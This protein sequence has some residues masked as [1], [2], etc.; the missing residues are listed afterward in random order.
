MLV[1][2]S[3]SVQSAIL[4]ALFFAVLLGFAAASPNSSATETQAVAEELVVTSA[5]GRLAVSGSV[6]SLSASQVDNLAPTHPADILSVQP[7]VWVSRGSGQEHLAGLRSPVLTGPGACGAYRILENGIP[8]RPIGFCNVNGL[9]ELPIRAGKQISVLLGGGG[10]ALGTASQYAALDLQTGYLPSG[11]QVQ[12]GTNGYRRL[13]LR[14]GSRSTGFE[15]TNVIDATMDDGW[16]ENTGLS[17]LRHSYARVWQTAAG[18][19]RLQAS[20]TL[21][22]QRTAGYIVVGEGETGK[23]ILSSASRRN[24]NENEGAY[25]TAGSLRLSYIFK[26]DA[27]GYQFAAW[28]RGTGMEFQQHFLPQK[29][30]EINGHI[31]GGVQASREAKLIDTQSA[32]LD[33]RVTLTGDFGEVHLRESQSE[34]SLCRFSTTCFPT[35]EHY[36]YRVAFIDAWIQG[37]LEGS[38]GEQIQLW[39]DFGLGSHTYIYRNQLTDGDACVDAA[40]MPL[41]GLDDYAPGRCRFFRPA[42][43]TDRA[44]AFSGRVAV[45][46]RP[47]DHLTSTLS[48]SSGYRPAQTGE[49]YRQ[50][51]ASQGV[52]LRIERLNQLELGANYALQDWLTASARFYL[53]WSRD[54]IFRLSDGTLEDS[55]SIN[56]RGM[57]WQL[58]AQLPWQSTLTL[59]ATFAHYQ[60]AYNSAN[61]VR[62]REVDTAPGEKMAL[63][64]SGSPLETVWTQL[65][66]EWLGAYY[67]DPSNEHSY[68]GHH[69][70]HLA[71]GWKPVQAFEV[72]LRI[73]NLLNSP[74]AE[75]ADFFFNERYF[76]GQ[77]I[78]GSATVQFNF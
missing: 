4:G 66:W 59:N 68:G 74:Y 35:G 47:F 19:H 63:I 67:T 48:F 28:L 12:L 10:A 49:L 62:G 69:L 44:V 26:P 50:Q 42:S 58:I 52:D 65:Q 27:G 18:S 9:I 31:S 78:N 25:R 20:N 73:R 45:Q 43:A 7:G 71:L 13:L 37:E 17:D 56:G 1:Q 46:Y 23:G 40:N 64:W 8:I 51:R 2:D 30:K 38:I 36:R 72:A 77:G 3:Q 14:H 5:F 70:V 29:P 6:Y 60:Y 33:Y 15:S 61:I 75:R 34:A 24:D 21:L 11:L 16:Q 41:E 54:L 22:H 55:G 57:E 39:G 53:Q 76:A 32:Q